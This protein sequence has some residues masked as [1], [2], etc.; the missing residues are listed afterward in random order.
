[1]F[2]IDLFPLIYYDWDEIVIN[3]K[4]EFEELTITKQFEKF[5]NLKKYKKLSLGTGEKIFVKSKK[6]I[7]LI[8]KQKNTYISLKLELLRGIKLKIKNDYILYGIYFKI[9]ISTTNIKK[10]FKYMKNDF[11]NINFTLLFIS[12][13]Y[14]L[15]DL[16]LE[17]III[18]NF[19]YFRDKNFLT[20][21]SRNKLVMI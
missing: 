3:T 1:M 21:N 13:P 18:E 17:Y 11:K 16:I 4:E 19:K 14:E 12:L 8:D 6:N 10:Y 5:L 9:H 20:I 2:Y 7:Y 15:I